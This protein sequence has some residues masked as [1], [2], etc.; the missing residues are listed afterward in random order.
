MM[1]FVV[2]PCLNE[3]ATLASTCESLGFAGTSHPPEDT[4]LILVDNGS[5]DGTRDV[6]KAI[7]DR[8]R[9]GSTLL[10]SET[11]RGYAPP[12][13]R[14][15]ELAREIMAQRR[16]TER[17]S[18][19]V[20]ADADTVYRPGYIRSVQRVAERSR[21]TLVH[22]RTRVPREFAASYPRYEKACEDAS[23]FVQPLCVSENEHIIVDDKVCAYWV[24]DY[25][26]W[27]G[28]TQEFDP[29]GNEVHA[30]TSRMFMRAKA[31]GA[32]LA[33]VDSAIAVPSRRKVCTGPAL[34][35]LTDGFPRGSHWVENWRDGY[36]RDSFHRFFADEVGLRGA[37][38][39]RWAHEVMLFGALPC[40]V[41]RAL[42]T[43]IA[44]HD[45][46]L[47]PLIDLLPAVTVHDLLHAPGQILSATLE[48]VDA[49]SS[50]IGN[51]IVA[52]VD[53]SER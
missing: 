44:S 52:T 40:A 18:L 53:P 1:T 41:A 9:P 8:S 47:A 32:R 48:A 31:R 14:G 28:H 13:R 11:T 38:V 50:K 10:A 35:Y 49:Q 4:V 24:N 25:L 45:R 21:N 16:C 7:A 12:R 6:M 43:P 27:G 2:I 26:T 20:Q 51:F 36:G 39:V 37:T 34:Y 3:E 15:V 22:G 17:A 23:A 29:D 46:M 30:E 42:G 19:I 5:S 33:H